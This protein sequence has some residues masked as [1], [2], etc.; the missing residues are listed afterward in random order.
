[1]RRVE[2]RADELGECPTWDAHSRRLLRIDVTGRRFLSCE[3]DGG[4]PEALSLA[5][6]PGSFALRRHGGLL[7]AYRRGLALRDPAGNETRLALPAD[8]DGSRERFNDGACD[9]YGR[10]WVGTM[11]RRL[12][13]T[14]GALYRVECDLTVRRMASGFGLS[15]GIAWSPDNR[16]MY[17]CDSRPPVIY[18]YDFDL[19]AGVVEN[20]RTLVEF[21]CE[22]GLPDGCAVDAE[23]F[24]WVAAP[25]AGEVMRF[26]PAGKLE[27][28]VRTVAASPTSVT[29]GGTDW[30]TLFITS[31]QPHEVSPGPADGAVFAWDAPVAGL[32]LNSFAA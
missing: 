27:R 18:A 24:L 30:Q 1:M 9:A 31:M 26:D 17:Q 13:D 2:A 3:F 6:I 21:S 22:M 14:V 23:G 25:Q 4:Q 19:E 12:Q 7:M 8:W 16:T 29:F 20:R 32:Q 5:E 15:N 10:F 28:A 11:D